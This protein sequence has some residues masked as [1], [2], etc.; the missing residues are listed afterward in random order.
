[1]I[2]RHLR[3][4][5]YAITDKI[6]TF[7]EKDPELLRVRYPNSEIGPGTYGW[8]HVLGWGE[9]SK[10]EIGAYCSISKN[11]TILLGGEH[12]MDWI[13]TYPFPTRWPSAAQITGHPRSKGNVVI[14]NDVWIGY[15]VMILSGVTIG[16][17]AVIGAGSVVASD[18]ASY[19][20]A[21]GNPAR[22]IRKRFSEDQISRLLTIRWWDWPKEEIE[23][24]LEKLC[25]NDL[26]AFFDYVESKDRTQ[27]DKSAHPG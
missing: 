17:G 22:S 3:L 10:L 26:P 18:V 23:P 21:A 11:V 6:R 19:T 8:I 15:G 4:W 14:G 20:I 9:G 27:L 5:V 13:T 24:V 1:M 12:R 25:S 7:L 2:T 16:D